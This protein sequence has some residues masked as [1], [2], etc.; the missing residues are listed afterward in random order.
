MRRFAVAFAIAAIG[1][2]ALHG[3]ETRS[4]TL[5]TTEHYLD[6]ERVN[7]AQISP[8]GAR[9]VYTRQAVNKLEDKWESSLWILNADGSQHRFLTKG[10]AARWSPDGKR[11]LYLAEGDPKG[12]SCSSA[13][14]RPTDRR[15]D[16]TCSRR[17]ATR[18]APDG[19]SLTFSMSSP[20]R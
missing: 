12:R 4:T 6:W 20:I 14:S 18:W 3:Q 19:K 10:S 15:P 17:R 8:D 13:G 2:I 5:L 1:S 7:D 11:L 16:L 9:I